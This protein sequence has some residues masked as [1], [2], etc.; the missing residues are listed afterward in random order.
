MGEVLTSD[1]A[2]AHRVSRE[3]GVLAEEHAHALGLARVTPRR[4]RRERKQLRVSAA[5]LLKPIRDERLV[6]V[7]RP[8]PPRSAGVERIVVRHG[9]LLEQPIEAH[10]HA[11]VEAALHQHLM[12]QKPRD[13]PRPSSK[14]ERTSNRP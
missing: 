4:Q 2:S 1:S 10:V 13:A 11:D 3:P 9:V 5:Q 14:G 12:S 8:I 7:S 6:G